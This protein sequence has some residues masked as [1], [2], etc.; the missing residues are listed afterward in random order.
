MN[1]KSTA[2]AITGGV[3]SMAARW[4]VT[5][6]M[7]LETA[8]HFGG[9]SDTAVDMAVLRDPREGSPLLPGTS[10]AGALRGHLADVLG[11]YRSKEHGDVAVL[12]GAAQR[13]DQGDQSPLIV[14]DS[15][16]ELPGGLAVE[17]RDGVAIDPATGTAE[18]H[19]KFDLEVLPAGTIFPVR[20]ELII[21]NAAAEPRLLNLLA[22][23]LEGLGEGDIALGM[24]RSRG[25]GT[26]NVSNWRA[27]RHNLANPDGWLGWLMTD[28]LAP[29]PNDVQPH[30]SPWQAIQAAYPGLTMKDIDDKDDKRARVVIEL[31]LNVVADLLVR[32]PAND[33]AAPDAVHLHSAGRP[34]LP[35][36]S[37]A[38]A[39]RAQAL[40]I[41]RLVRAS[42]GD[43]DLWVKRLSGD[44]RS[45]SSETDAEECPLA[46]SK[47]RISEA[48]INNSIPRRQTRIAIDRFTGG[49]VQ[50]A[51]F[52]E[53]VQTGG[54]LDVRLEL[55]NPDHAETGLLLLLLKDLLAG[56]VP[57]GGAASVGRG[58]LEGTAKIRFPGGAEHAIGPDLAVGEETRKLFNSRITAF[59][60]AESL[61][62]EEVRS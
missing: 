24:R 40:K 28:H 11:G 49:V 10:L 14:F 20:V 5:G 16:G 62:P 2:S 60:E 51:L 12:F 3:R 48:F 8:A 34:V 9:E 6:R 58:V 56:E 26:V 23:T 29:I 21:A 1:D 25:L 38:G 31:T 17:I 37:L 7:T 43:G 35:G 39:L 27:R 57:V 30:G 36:T 4:V 55:R 54:R 41:A 18:A 53:Q 50:G 52:D 33:A 59:H 44:R 46:A 22:R 19:K 32:G 47:L 15:L 13:D 61:K 45:E 42:A